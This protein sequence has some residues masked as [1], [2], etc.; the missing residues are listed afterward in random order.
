MTADV[1]KN[2][3]FIFF[4]FFFCFSK[5]LADQGEARGCFTNTVVIHYLI[6]A[7]TAPLRPNS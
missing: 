4:L 3:K 6:S 1:H 7:F 2:K 5:F